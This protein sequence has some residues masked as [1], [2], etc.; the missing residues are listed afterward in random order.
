M[1]LENLLDVPFR[2]LST[3]QKK[4]SAFARLLNQNAPIWLLDE[5]LN[6]LDNDAKEQVESLIN[7]HCKGG[8]ICIAASHQPIS[9]PADA[10][11]ISL[12]DFAL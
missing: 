10:K 2:F 12:E 7:L 1:G 9:L 3:G 5:P 4:R 11:R 8:G 6:G